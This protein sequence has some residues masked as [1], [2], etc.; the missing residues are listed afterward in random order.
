MGDF[1]CLP[2][3]LVDSPL[4]ALELHSPESGLLTFPSWSPDRHID[5]ILLSPTLKATQTEV[6]DG[7]RLSDHLPL[8]TEILLPEDVLEAARHAQLSI[9]DQAR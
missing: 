8:S 5:H 9:T 4:A 6:I 7:C 2:E 3:H 1:N